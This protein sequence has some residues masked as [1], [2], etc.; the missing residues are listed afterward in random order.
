MTKPNVDELLPH[1]MQSADINYQQKLKLT[2]TGFVAGGRLPAPVLLAPP[3][4][5]D[6]LEGL[7]RFAI[8]VR[9]LVKNMGAEVAGML[10][11]LSVS[12]DK[13]PPEPSVVLYVDQKFGGVRVFVAPKQGEHLVFRDLGVARPWAN[14]LPALIPI[15][16]Y[17]S[18][19][20]EA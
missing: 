2:G 12:I 4:A 19:V 16:A 20:A 9:E 7:N 15:E 17:G 10:C 3:R 11:E 14:F 13:S 18:F 6:T 8:A 1:L 5:V